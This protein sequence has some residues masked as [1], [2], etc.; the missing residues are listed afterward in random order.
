LPEFFRKANLSTSQLSA[1]R[2]TFRHRIIR[3]AMQGE[4]ETE[5]RRK[6]TS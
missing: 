1:R 5:A 6:K 2:R 3:Q 4:T